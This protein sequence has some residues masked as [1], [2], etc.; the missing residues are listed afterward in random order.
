MDCL[1]KTPTENHLGIFHQAPVAWKDFSLSSTQGAP[2]GIQ[3]QQLS[4]ELLSL[5]T[6][7]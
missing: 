7:H 6:E 1:D 2:L 5:C 3:I 4:Q